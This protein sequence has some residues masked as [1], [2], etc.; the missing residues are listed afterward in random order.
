MIV[1]PKSKA[2]ETPEGTKKDPNFEAMEEA[3]QGLVKK[4]GAK[5]VLMLAVWGDDAQHLTASQPGVALEDITEA[6]LASMQAASQLIR[7]VNKLQRA[8]EKEERL[9]KKAEA[10]ERDAKSE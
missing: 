2:Q 7:Q 4:S 5:M 1:I 10:E 6:A 8:K 3:I 9:D